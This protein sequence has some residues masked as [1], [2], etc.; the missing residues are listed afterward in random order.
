[1]FDGAATSA[2]ASSQHPLTLH[3]ATGSTRTGG[4]QDIGTGTNSILPSDGRLGEITGAGTYSNLCERRLAFELT[5]HPTPEQAT[6]ALIH[7]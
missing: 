6:N 3:H 2:S 5:N 4:F 1:M 7:R